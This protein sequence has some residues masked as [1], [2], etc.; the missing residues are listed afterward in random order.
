MYVYAPNP[1]VAAFAYKNI[2]NT[3]NNNYTAFP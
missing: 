3:S 2:V 1:P